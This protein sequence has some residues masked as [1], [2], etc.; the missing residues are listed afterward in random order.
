MLSLWQPQRQEQAHTFEMSEGN[1]GDREKA[2]ERKGQEK[3]AG[4]KAVHIHTAHLL[5]GTW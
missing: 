3:G 4:N 2:E 1:W 5:R